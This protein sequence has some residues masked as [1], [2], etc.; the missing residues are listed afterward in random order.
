[1]NTIEPSPVE[2]DL[3]PRPAGFRSRRSPGL[4]AVG[5]LFAAV[6]CSRP[7]GQPDAAPPPAAVA[8]V[9]RTDLSQK[10]AVAS[11]FIPFQEVDVHAKIAGYVREIRFDIGDYVRGG[12][13]IAI[14]DVPEQLDD[15]K[16]TRAAQRRWREEIVQARR[17]LQRFEA[18]AAERSVTYRRLAAVNAESPKLIA[19]QEID[20]ARFQAEAAAA[21]VAARRAAVA[22]AE[23][24][25]AEADAAAQRAEALARYA[26]VTAPFDGVVVKRYADT[27]ALIPAATQTSDQSLPLV[28][29]AQVDPLRLSFPVPEPNIASV[30]VGTPVVITVPAL[31][32]TMV[33]QVWRFSGK[34]D[35]ATRTMQTQVL[36]AN[37]ARLLKP[38]MV[39]T[40]ELTTEQRSR[41]L[42]IPV[43][44]VAPGSDRHAAKVLVVGAG[45]VVEE[46][47]VR[48]GLQTATRYEVIAG[49][50]EQERVIV[51]QQSRFRPGA[52][53]IPK[54]A[55]A[56]AGSPG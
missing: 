32:Q 56:T 35:Q 49:L 10:L 20:I 53:V 14:L 54:P 3:L 46:R 4:F 44:A 23:Q 29:L 19:Q 55:P 37:P 48:L 34:A 27:G 33:G 25:S 16:L 11:E 17:E 12:E 6:G 41:V 28:R 50:Q 39:A 9:V 40:V 45:D 8:A 47:S 15:V 21:D 13:V 52:K 38:G 2:P 18:I 22:V 24:R 26:K 7:E 36:I 30:R 42:T 5:L 1:M 51:A 43:E 31:G